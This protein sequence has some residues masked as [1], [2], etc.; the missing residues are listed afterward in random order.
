MKVVISY[1]NGSTSEHPFKTMGEARYF[2]R[3]GISYSG[4][5]VRRV[6]VH[7]GGSAFAVWDISWDEV[8]NR[9]GLYGA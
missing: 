4:G 3:R 6:E 7:E 5:R 1:V 9:A 2:Y 8:S